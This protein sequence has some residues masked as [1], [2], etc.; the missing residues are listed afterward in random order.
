MK[1]PRFRTIIRLIS[2]PAIIAGS[3]ATFTLASASPA[4][5]GITV[6]VCDLE[7]G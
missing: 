1:I 7:P 4:A 2:G 3:L 6:P 5:A